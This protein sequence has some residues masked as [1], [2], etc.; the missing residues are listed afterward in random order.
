MEVEIVENLTLMLVMMRAL[1]PLFLAYN[2]F[3]ATCRKS[4]DMGINI[5]A[6]Q[7]RTCGWL[8]GW[9]LISISPIN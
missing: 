7:I 1:A 3:Y 9:Y 6:S 8:N 4:S 5:A 2:F